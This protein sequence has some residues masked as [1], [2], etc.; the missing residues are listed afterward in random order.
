MEYSFNEAV[1]WLEDGGEVILE[2]DGYDYEISRADDWI[3]GDG[4][5]GYISL[6]LGNVVYESAE[7]ILRQS[8]NFLEA[9]G[10]K[11]QIRC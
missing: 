10:Q 9:D 4:M 1:E 7:S 11:V 3:G 2:C 6:V 8:I 5:D